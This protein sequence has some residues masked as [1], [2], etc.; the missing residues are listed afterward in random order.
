M[1]KI[2]KFNTRIN[3][4]RLEMEKGADLNK[5]FINLISKSQKRKPTK[6]KNCNS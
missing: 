4:I 2:K 1:N 5:N 6:L 3:S